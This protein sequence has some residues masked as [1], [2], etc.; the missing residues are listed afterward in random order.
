MD[1]TYADLC[2]SRMVQRYRPYVDQLIQRC[3]LPGGTKIFFQK[4]LAPMFPRDDKWIPQREQHLL[5]L[6]D[7]TIPKGY[8]CATRGFFKTTSLI[9]YMIKCIVL[10]EQTF[11]L[12]TSQTEDNAGVVTD[13]VRAQVLGNTA[14][15]TVFG[16]LRPETY[17]GT[18]PVFSKKAWV[19]SD[20][21]TGAPFFAATPKGEGQ[22]V[23]GALF[24]IRG[25]LY[26]PTFLS[27]DDGE[28]RT[29]VLQEEL[30][31]KHDAWYWGAFLPCVNQDA[32]PDPKTHRWIPDGPGWLP[33]Y[34]IIHQDT[35]K[36]E[37]ANMATIMQSQEW[38]GHVFPK[39]EWKDVDGEEKLCSCCAELWSDEEVRSEWDAFER[40]GQGD[41]FAMEYMCQP[42]A[43][44][45][46][47]WSKKMFKYYDDA[48]S[49]F[50][51]QADI[52]RFII[53]DP[54]K[55]STARSAYSAVTAV[56]ADWKSKAIYFRRSIIDRVHLDVLAQRVFSLACE[57]NSPDV[58]IEITGLESAITTIFNRVAMDMRVNDWINLIPLDARSTMPRGDYGT[59]KEAVKRARASLVLPFYRLGM[60]FHDISLRDKHVEKQMLFFPKC[61]YW[62]GLDTFGYVPIVLERDGR[63]DIPTPTDTQVPIPEIR[64]K[65]PPESLPKPRERKPQKEYT[66]RFEFGDKPMRIGGGRVFA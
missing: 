48:T 38:F 2:D 21:I 57:M 43:R 56:A 49:G 64:F 46:D 54:A 26:R 22:Q 58:W 45:S 17:M 12:H 11:W 50:N 27:S 9:G 52:I 36:H 8:I 24:P 14:I 59:G 25:Y 16:N 55:T 29:D 42:M 34:R 39:C 10:R 62:D 44:N 7:N 18:N 31:K 40:R 41:I 66:P 19:L 51:N 35:L 20:P 5:F 65:I 13:A 1:L 3:Y 4:F 63:F 15:Q 37:S 47:G 33:P 28:S 23:N 6:E 32:Y 61:S 30:R 53:V 60:M